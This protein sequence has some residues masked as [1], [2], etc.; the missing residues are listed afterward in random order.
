M[1]DHNT[2]TGIDMRLNNL[3]IVV[4]LAGSVLSGCAVNPVTG[5]SQLS[6]ITEEDEIAMGRKQYLPSQ[7]AQGGIF[8]ADPEVSR[9]VNEVGER[10]ISVGDRWLPYEFVVLNNSA[11]NAW[12][13]PG[14]KIGINRGLLLEL[15]NEAELAAVLAHETVHA[16]A[17]HGA[18]SLQREQIIQGLVLATSMASSKTDFGHYIVDGA[19]IGAQIISQTYGRRA[20]LEADY[21]GIKYLDRAGYDPRAAVTLQQKLKALSDH[22]DQNV[23]ADLF[24]SHPPL[25]SPNRR[26]H[27]DNPTIESQTRGNIPSP[28][29]V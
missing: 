2:Q 13:L 20:E 1:P 17:K 5:K 28:I 3:L 23:L 10:V 12:A 18:N 7:Q 4:L 22:S 19:E 29:Q 8:L 21:Y 15:S 9:Y 6:W 24:S 25:T 27:Q 16:A 11:L 14:G 26:K